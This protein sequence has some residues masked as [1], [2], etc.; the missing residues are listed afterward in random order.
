MGYFCNFRNRRLVIQQH[1]IIEHDEDC[2]GSPRL[3]LV[4]EFF[5][6]SRWIPVTLSDWRSEVGIT[7]FLAALYHFGSQT[8]TQLLSE[9]LFIVHREFQFIYVS[10]DLGV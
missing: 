3:L 2:F 4:D 6:F 9:D 1:K 7:C 5:G 8:D 10:R